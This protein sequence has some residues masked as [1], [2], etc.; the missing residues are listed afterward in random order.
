VADEKRDQRRDGA[1]SSGV[2]GDVS[3]LPE[4][5]RIQVE[6]CL[7]NLWAEWFGGWALTHDVNGVSTLEGPVAD[8]AALFGLL[9]RVRDAGLTL[10]S[11]HQVK[12]LVGV[13]GRNTTAPLEL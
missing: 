11:V 4:I 7:D 9:D 5:Y 8:Q 1:P 2:P 10:V 6:G 13:F 3:G 12:S